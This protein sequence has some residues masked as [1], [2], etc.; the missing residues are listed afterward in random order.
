MIYSETIV[1]IPVLQ[2]VYSSYTLNI[3]YNP[4]G[5]SL[6]SHDK[7]T[8]KVCGDLVVLCGESAQVSCDCHYKVCSFDNKH[9]V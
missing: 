3:I 1:S 9:T 7:I 6:I 5:L 4:P 8:I 2:M